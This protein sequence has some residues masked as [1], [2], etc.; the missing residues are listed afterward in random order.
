MTELTLE[1]HHRLVQG[2]LARLAAR[3]EHGVPQL[4]ETH[5][6]SVILSGDFAYKIKKPVDFGFLDFSTLERRRH[7]CAEE[8]RLNGRLAPQI[9]LDVIA[10][11]G[12][13]EC[14]ELEGPGDAL[15]YAVRMRR[16]SQD[17]LLSHLAN[18][19]ALDIRSM[20]AVAAQVADFH[21]RAA[22]APSDSGFCTAQAAF[23][24]VQENFE[25]LRPLITGADSVA[26]LA[27]LEQW[28]RDRYATLRE[29]LTARGATGWIRECHGDMHLG[30]MAL[31]DEAVVIFDGIEFSERLRWTDVLGD[32]AFLAMDLDDRGLRSHG[33][34]FLSAWLEHSGDYGALHLLNYYRVY[35]AMVRAK[36]DA[37]RL[38]QPLSTAEREQVLA[39]YHGYAD[40]AE[41]YTR[42]T[43][44][45]LCITHG[46]SG[47]GKSTAAL[48]LVDRHGMLR[49]RSDVERKRLHGLA[50]VARSGSSLGAGIYDA[51]TTRAT[52]ARLVE[53]A[54][55]ALD[56]GF[57]VV[58]D[59]AFLKRWQRQLF[60]E[61]AARREASFAI[62]DL[63][64][65][66]Q[67]L[68]ER[69][70]RRQARGGDPSEADVAVLEQQIADRE[71][72]TDE[73]LAA[74]VR[75]PA[76]DAAAVIAALFISAT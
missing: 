4:I 23:F 29:R 50:P 7:F 55:T 21:A 42:S 11:S 49:I 41:R 59:A 28:S 75:L 35:R 30:N 14:P 56:A 70:V 44:P 15:E 37:L 45:V 8:I 40:L 73:E 66:V 6:S 74:R 67:E 69:L 22:K 46:L 52:Y 34:R 60:A 26:Q 39:E 63:E 62:L 5:I 9:Y 51:D 32:V 53:I 36:I 2:L 17:A 10:I 65:P 1:D 19:G 68:R 16:F 31:I 48:E 64:V 13:I 43:S 61:L 25:Q 72:L 71:P 58:V 54:E 18:A 76:G 24:P 20:D 57:P 12:S 3:D 27:R 38:T 33:N 47:S